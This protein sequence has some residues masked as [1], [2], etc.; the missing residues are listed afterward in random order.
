MRQSFRT[1]SAWRGLAPV[2]A[3]ACLA[4]PA[5]A[6]GPDR[7][8]DVTA[9]TDERFQWVTLGT[10][11]GP[12]PAADRHQP[13]NLLTDGQAAYLIDAGDGAASEMASTGVFFPML[14]AVWI[15]HIHFDHIGGLFALLGLRVQTRTTTPLIIYGPPGMTAI[16]DKLIDAERP[17]AGLGFGVP[18]EVPIDP[19]AGIS[20]VEVDD[21]SLIRID[22][23]T[24]RVARN[25][26]YGF[27]PGS[28]MD[29]RF[30]SLSFRFDLPGRSIV[31]TGDTGPCPAVDTLAEGADLLVSEMIDIDDTIARVR[32]HSPDLPAAELARIE[33]HLR[34]QH[35]TPADIGALAAAAH[36]GAV[37]I[38][39]IASGGDPEALASGRYVREVRERYS[40]PVTIARDGARF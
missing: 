3:L 38:T 28:A 23:F 33:E 6:S 14:R 4:M 22:G 12:M 37:A 19:A 29:E 39:H 7:S 15:S 9:R 1:Q 5:V 30:R 21:G 20:V 26:H 13:A 18:G 35:L 17:G 27:P 11:G 40:G 32:R 34:T 31:Y 2:L 36:V 10:M 24:V 8:P 25:C 16:V